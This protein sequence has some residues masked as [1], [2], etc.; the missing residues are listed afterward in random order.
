[1]ASTGIVR[2]SGYFFLDT[3][4]LSEFRWFHDSWGYVNFAS[5]FRLECQIDIYSVPNP[6]LHHTQQARM[7]RS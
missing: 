6:A 7:S 5:N 4:Y 2:V 1:M 3:Y